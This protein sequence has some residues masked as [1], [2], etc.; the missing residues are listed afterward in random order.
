M[1]CLGIA[2]K[3]NVES[4]ERTNYML[5]AIAHSMLGGLRDALDYAAKHANQPEPGSPL[6]PGPQFEEDVDRP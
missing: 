5:E 1:D 3:Y 4:P 6:Y 2:E